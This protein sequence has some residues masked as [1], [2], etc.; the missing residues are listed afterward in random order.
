MYAA[1]CRAPACGNSPFRQKFLRRCGTDPAPFGWSGLASAL[2]EITGLSFIAVEQ[3]RTNDET[4]P[5]SPDFNAGRYETTAE[6]LMPVARMGV[7]YA[8]LR[9]GERVLDVGCG[10][11]NVALLAAAQPGVSVTG[12][13]PAERLL[14]VARQRAADEGADVTFALGEAARLPV[15]DATIDVVI[16]VSAMIFAPDPAAVAAEVSRVLATPGRVILT[17]W[18]PDGPLRRLSSMFEEAARQAAGKEPPAAPF[19]WHD[20]QALATL[21][22]SHGFSVT[23]Q[24]HVLIV[25]AP[26]P[27]EYLRQE[28]RD[29]PTAV[30]GLPA[31]DQVGQRAALRAKLLAFLESVNED[32]NAFRVV[33]PYTVAVARR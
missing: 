4:E 9:P 5:A 12:V 14:E 31:V 25:T 11:G 10:T 6:R 29:H 30:A 7:R 32:P 2:G 28:A 17:A 18:P 13:D 1:S 20:R 22:G 3:R 15:S 8:R 27:G 19:P 26:S 21:F 33:S 24:R 16:S 23:V